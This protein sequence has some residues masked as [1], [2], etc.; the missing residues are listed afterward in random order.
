METLLL[1]LNRNKKIWRRYKKEKKPKTTE[2][3]VSGLKILI[4][5]YPKEVS[6]LL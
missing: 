3:I 4:S 2:S 1:L 6:L 5:K